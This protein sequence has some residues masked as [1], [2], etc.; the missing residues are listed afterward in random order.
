KGHNLLVCVCTSEVHLLPCATA[1][2]RHSNVSQSTWP[3]SYRRYC[4]AHQPREFHHYGNS[5]TGRCAA[6]NRAPV[7]NLQAADLGACQVYA[8]RCLATFGRSLFAKL[9]SFA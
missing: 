9:W 4:D 2:I 7:P 5:S 1:N 3:E 8:G 6:L